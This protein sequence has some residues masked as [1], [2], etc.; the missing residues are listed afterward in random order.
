[1]HVTPLKMNTWTVTNSSF[2]D[3]CI[4]EDF[5]GILNLLS[6]QAIVWGQ[7]V[8]SSLTFKPFTEKHLSSPCVTCLFFNTLF[9]YSYF[10]VSERTK[11]WKKKEWNFSEILKSWNDF[12]QMAW[13]LSQSIV[14][15]S[16]AIQSYAEFSV[17]QSRQKYAYRR[18]WVILGKNTRTPCNKYFDSSDFLKLLT[19]ILKLLHSNTWWM[20][21]ANL[22]FVQ[23]AKTRSTLKELKDLA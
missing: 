18:K 22:V 4:C 9:L 8:D 21:L 23:Q 16:S 15:Y 2:L 1:M 14:A 12:N 19:S 17:K 11:H 5:N 7:I 20:V 13:Y 10:P 3:L 6:F